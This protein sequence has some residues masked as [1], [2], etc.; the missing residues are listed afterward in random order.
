MMRAIVKAFDL[1]GDDIVDLSTENDFLK[2]E[3]G[4]YDAK[5]VKKSKKKTVKIDR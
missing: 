2:N 1:M 5:W 4:D 3:T